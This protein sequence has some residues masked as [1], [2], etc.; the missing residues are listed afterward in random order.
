MQT[1]WEQGADGN[2]HGVWGE[3]VLDIAQRGENSNAVKL[4]EGWMA[5][6]AAAKQ[7][8]STVKQ[9]V[10]TQQ[11]MSKLDFL[12]IFGVMVQSGMSKEDARLIL[13]AAYPEA[14]EFLA[15]IVQKQNT[16]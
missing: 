13:G 2:V 8:S 10:L 15:R 6:E 12:N 1:L 3:T 11:G 16:R 7:N 5:K 14:T 4:L 9:K